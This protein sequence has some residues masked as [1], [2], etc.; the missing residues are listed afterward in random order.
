MLPLDGKDNSGCLSKVAAQRCSV[1]SPP[2]KTPTGTTGDVCTLAC[3][4]EFAPRSDIGIHQTMPS[5]HGLSLS[6]HQ[7]TRRGSADGP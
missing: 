6:I 4:A 2:W 7:R 5:E 3:H 1:S